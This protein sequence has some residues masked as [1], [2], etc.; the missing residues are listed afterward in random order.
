MY[1]RFAK[2]PSSVDESWHEF[3]KANP[4][5][6][7]AS[8]R[9]SS[10]VTAPTSTVAGEKK[11]AESPTGGEKKRAGNA[12][13]VTVD[14]VTPTAT[15]RDVAAKPDSN[16]APARQA[17][18]Q[19]V[20]APVR[21]PEIRNKP[22]IPAPARSAQPEYTPPEEPENTVL[23]GPAGAIVKNMNASLTLP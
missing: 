20:P 3:F 14:D 21:T 23:R 22:D 7:S 11:P 18:G 16:A 8:G 4:R 12:S 5:A 9:N 15:A 19:G 10:T 2:D 1:E 6:A 13:E 17:R